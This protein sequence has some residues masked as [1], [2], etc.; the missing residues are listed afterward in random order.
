VIAVTFTGC[1]LA[2]FVADHALN[3][4]N[5]VMSIAAPISIAALLPLPLRRQHEP[6]SNEVGPAKQA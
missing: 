5:V 3:V 2:L 1:A 6:K 4:Q